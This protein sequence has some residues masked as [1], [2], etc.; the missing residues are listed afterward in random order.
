MH[1]NIAKEYDV[2]L[3]FHDS[4]DK[5]GSREQAKRLYRHLTAAGISCFL[6]SEQEESVYK[7]NF[8]KIMQAR[9]LILVCNGNIARL[10][11]GELDAKKNYHLYVEL[12]TFF[13]M[14][15]SDKISCSV[16]DAAVVCFLPGGS[17][18]SS[19]S[20]EKIHPLFDQ[21]NSFFYVNDDAD[22]QDEE[23]ERVIDWVEER[24]DLQNEEDFSPELLFVSNQRK[25]DLQNLKVLGCD[26]R[27]ILRKATAIKCLGISNWTFSLTDG[28]IKLKNALK[29]GVS[30]EM[31]FLDPD[32]E[33][34]KLRAR[35]ENKDT[36]GQITSSF[37]MI[38]AE[39]KNDPARRGC[40]KSYVYDL[41]P[42]DNL[43]FIYSGEGD[44]VFVQNYS[45]A[46]PGS[47]A[48]Q[49]IYVKRRE[50]PI[51]DYYE[52]IYHYV[53]SHERTREYDIFGE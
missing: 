1:M 49:Y 44:F 30:C 45:H 26:F 29:R 23:I 32:G 20:L 42:R 27:R 4:G 47:A 40:F 14:T 33:G 28:C 24:L 22:D 51:F 8:I 5:N 15:Q 13:A 50:S 46:L 7:A 12:D 9:L 41:V 6:F 38:K 3:A 36:R 18:R 31:L 48:P 19:V 11:T 37:D 21:R 39:L 43:I 16:N 35:E 2:F 53:L 52:G 25:L 17:T 34:V 10:K